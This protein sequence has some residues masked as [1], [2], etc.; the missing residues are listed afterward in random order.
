MGDENLSVYDVV[1]FLEVEIKL[2]SETMV[3]SI[4]L[5]GPRD[6]KNMAGE[7]GVQI[8]VCRLGEH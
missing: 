3:Y 1:L 5:S 6:S 2:N 8:R 4:A 7:W